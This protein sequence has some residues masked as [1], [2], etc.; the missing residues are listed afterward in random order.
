MIGRN[1]DDFSL[2]DLAAAWEKTTQWVQ[3]VPPPLLTRT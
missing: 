1:H 2:M 3:K